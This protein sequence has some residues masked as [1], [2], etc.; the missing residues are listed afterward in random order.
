MKLWS[1]HQDRLSQG[2]QKHIGRTVSLEER[3]DGLH[4]A[5][6]VLHTAKGDEALEMA[7]E[8][9][10]RGLSVG[11]MPAKGGTRRA[12]DGVLERVVGARSIMSR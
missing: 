1:S 3:A 10:L 8:G 7:R 9:E 6:Q 5:W 12:A 4:G 2:E 11:F